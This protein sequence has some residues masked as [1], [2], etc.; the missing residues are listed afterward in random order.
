ML[1]GLLLCLLLGDICVAQEITARPP[2][3]STTVPP[4]ST[5]TPTTMSTGAPQPG[6]GTPAPGTTQP[7][8]PGTATPAPAQPQVN[9]ALASLYN[10]MTVSFSFAQ[11]I[12]SNWLMSDENYLAVK[13]GIQA[14]QQRTVGPFTLRG[15]LNFGLGVNYRDDS[16][17]GRNFQTNDNEIFT[18]VMA[19]YPVK[20]MIDPYVATNVRT[21]ITESYRYFGPMYMRMG[22]F[23]D[24]ITTQQSAGFSFSR[25]SADGI[26]NTRIG[27][28]LQQVRA[29][30][31]T[32]MT[33]DFTTFN[34]IER[35]KPT[36]GIEFVNDV[37]LRAD[38]TLA[39][40]AHFGV[41]TG[42]KDLSVWSVHWD[43][44]T[45]FQLWKS[46]GLIWTFNVIHD[47]TQTR[48]TQFKQSL[49]IGVIRSF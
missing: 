2:D 21:A 20:W 17:P 23:R 12:S 19:I 44:E 33:D 45:R 29:H 31:Q 6:P 18:E 35:Y 27:F 48:K 9:A 22:S 13:L 34:V 8:N 25:M 1:K 42:F 15:T 14:R 30:Y 28:L 38:T 16:I 40:T 46:I 43:N 36:S 49:T 37:A 4:P 3:A 32:L 5:G 10:G 11:S 39:F 41:A 26:F 24:P 47:V 7:S